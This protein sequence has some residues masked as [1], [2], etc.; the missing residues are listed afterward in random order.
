MAV[1]QK[2]EV[3]LKV[4]VIGPRGLVG[5]ELLRLLE[6][7][8]WVDQLTLIST[9]SGVSGKIKF[10]GAG[11]PL[12]GW[13][14]FLA[15]K[16]SALNILISLAD[17][18][19]SKQYLKRFFGASQFIIDESSAFRMNPDVP[20]IIPEINGSLIR[21]NPPKLV[22]SPN[23]TT[24]VLALAVAPFLKH[25]PIRRIVTASYQAASGAGRDARDGFVKELKFLASG[26]LKSSRAFAQILAGNVL[27]QIGS[28]SESGFSEEEE[29]VAA[30]T[31]KILGLSDMPI[32]A[33]CVR[34]PVLRGHSLAVW[35]ELEKPLPAAGSLTGVYEGFPG[36][37]F[38]DSS[39]PTPLTVDSKPG[40]YVGR[41][42][43]DPVWPNGISLWASGDN[44]LKGAAQNV[45][46][47]ADLVTSASNGSLGAR[48]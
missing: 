19:W 12:L 24:V 33:T 34:V 36:V 46:D 47:I 6:K 20:L 40:V 8:K 45:L 21:E 11:V 15:P 23:C 28:F 39:Y 35:V 32:S 17:A 14:K 26:K 43:R 38:S 48:L 3:S 18:G 37:H 22:A 4:G 30:E 7:K 27:P 31:R 10:R 16:R 5:E 42:R 9:E 2:R 29:K 13:A 41:V 25:S 1:R 44:L